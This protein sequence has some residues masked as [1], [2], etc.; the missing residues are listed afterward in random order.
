MGEPNTVSNDFR[1]LRPG[2]FLSTLLVLA[3]LDLVVLF[4]LFNPFIHL[5]KAKEPS[6]ATVQT[7]A[8]TVDDSAKPSPFGGVRAVSQRLSATVHRAYDRSQVALLTVAD[9][10]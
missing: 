10:K 1:A 4:W 7:A 5:V 2:A 3:V 9:Q 6:T 8:H